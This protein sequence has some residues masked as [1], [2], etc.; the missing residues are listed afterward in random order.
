[1]ELD[2]SRSLARPGRRI[3]RYQWRLHNDREIEGPRTSV[4]ADRPGLFSEELR[5]LADD[6]SEDRDYAQLRVWNTQSGAAF[7]A[8]W[9]YHWP[10]RGARPGTQILFWNRLFGTTGPV[11]I[12][13]GDDSKPVR[14]GQEITHAYGKAGLYTAALRSRGP[15]DEPVEVRMR[16]VI[17]P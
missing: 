12:D 5:L 9:F 15:A 16:V 6:G 3:V 8:G 11:E 13:F 14:I 2:A 4:Q 1:V 17:D 10:V 7:A